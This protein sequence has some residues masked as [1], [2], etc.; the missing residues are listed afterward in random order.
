MLIPPLA[1][2]PAA[3]MGGRSAS[4]LPWFSIISTAACNELLMSEDVTMQ[5][6][7]LTL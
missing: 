2:S 7:G 5:R 3:I 1:I 6:T 4:N